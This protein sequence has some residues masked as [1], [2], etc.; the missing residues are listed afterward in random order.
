MN[1]KILLLIPLILVLIYIFRS[2]KKEQFTTKVSK[3][4]PKCE[5]LL[6]KIYNVK[7]EKILFKDLINPQLSKSPSEDDNTEPEDVV[8]LFNAQTN[9]KNECLEEEENIDPTNSNLITSHPLHYGSIKK[10]DKKAWK[11]SNNIRYTLPISDGALTDTYDS[12]LGDINK[13]SPDVINNLEKWKWFKDGKFETSQDYI[14]EIPYI[15]GNKNIKGRKWVN[16][17]ST[18]DYSISSNENEQP[19]DNYYMDHAQ[20]QTASASV[21]NK[22]E[23]ELDMMKNWG[24]KYTDNKNRTPENESYTKE[25]NTIEH[26]V[27]LNEIFLDEEK[28]KAYDGIPQYILD[29]KSKSCSFIAS[30]SS[31]ALK[32]SIVPLKKLYD[33]YPPRDIKDKNHNDI[34]KSKD[35]VTLE[36][37]DKYVYKRKIIP[38]GGM[39]D[40][41]EDVHHYGKE[42][43][44]EAQKPT[45]ILANSGF[46]STQM[47]NDGNLIMKA[48]AKY[49]FKIVQEKKCPEPL[50]HRYYFEKPGLP[51]HSAWYIGTI[52]GSYSKNLPTHKKKKLSDEPPDETKCTMCSFPAGCKYPDGKFSSNYYEQQ[53]CG[54]GKDRI[55]KKCRTC[56]MGLEVVDTDCG[57]GGG[58]NDRSCCACTE[59]PDGTYKVYGCDKPNSYYDTECKPLSK[60]YGHKPESVKET[61]D[62]MDRFPKY[63]TLN[64]YDNDPGIGKRSYKLKD[65]LKGGYG[66]KG[67]IDPV[68]NKPILNPYFGRDTKCAKCDTCPTGWK[69][70]RGCLGTNDDENTICQRTINKNQYLAK[71]FTC[72]KGKFYSKDRISSKIDNLNKQL[73]KDDELIR[74]RINNQNIDIMKDPERF[75]TEKLININD[76]KNFPNPIPV[77]TDDDLKIIGCTTCSI[78]PGKIS[79]RNPDSP[80]CEAQTDTI[81]KPHTPCLESQYISK[82]GDS[83]NDQSCSSCRCPQPN[84]FGIADCTQ[85]ATDKNGTIVPKGCKR[86]IDCKPGEFIAD[87]PGVYGDTTKSRVCSTCKTCPYGTFTLE[88]GC[89]PGGATDTICKNWKQCDKET[90]IV[91]EPGT[92]TKDTICKCIDGYELPKNDLGKVDLDAQKCDLI[93]GKCHTNPC[94]PKANCYD[95]FTD[96]GDYLNTVCKCDIDNGFI[97]TQDK[98]FGVNG[99]FS[100]PGKHQHEIKTP[101]ASF[102]DLPPKFAKVL[103]H[104]DKDYHRKKTGTHLH[105]NTPLQIND[106]GDIISNN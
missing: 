49:D 96:N 89:R 99:C 6:T 5:K 100:V 35:I 27:P 31:K 54:D 68:T 4:D 1:K 106:N 72:P 70:L 47:N 50:P 12:P 102:G 10:G 2:L 46:D 81:C 103:T 7:G 95:N 17:G 58:K 78:C 97:Q 11:T 45:K 42:M 25:G 21:P 75:K 20:Y 30:K 29:Q 53:A 90:M 104:L 56:K 64:T 23:K 34:I 44:N 14:D 91:I 63:N 98:G 52:G 40:N 69:H 73:E 92:S 39:E 15:D 65:G 37:Y 74:K 55:C 48:E 51:N 18:F 77:L 22:N 71:N 3:V 60:C 9:Y 87:D 62:Y 43:T 79:H 32:T 59:C 105:K 93:I 61:N 82:K 94:H 67:K 76:P 66:D 8:S 80:G 24:T 83:F 36:D 101:A 16:D 13:E 84:Y 38:E 85:T 86:K 28:F 57:E 88:G 19:K 41:L 33:N 26:E